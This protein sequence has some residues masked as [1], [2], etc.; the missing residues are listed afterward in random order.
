VRTAGVRRRAI[1]DVWCRTTLRW[2]FP[3][4]GSHPRR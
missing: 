2:P 3:P 1:S 4:V